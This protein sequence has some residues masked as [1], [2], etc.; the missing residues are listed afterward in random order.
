MGKTTQLFLDIWGLVRDSSLVV[1][2]NE[3]RKTQEKTIH[4]CWVLFLVEGTPT[5]HHECTVR[6]LA[7]ARQELGYTGEKLETFIAKKEQEF[8]DREERVRKREEE[9]ERPVR[10]NSM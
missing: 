6:E 9:R 10:R 3:Y 4:R 8:L 1:S 7:V 2:K 5:V